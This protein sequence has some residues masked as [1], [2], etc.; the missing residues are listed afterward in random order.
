MRSVGGI[1]GC[2]YL[3]AFIVAPASGASLLKG[4]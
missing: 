4:E 1:A 2:G 3:G